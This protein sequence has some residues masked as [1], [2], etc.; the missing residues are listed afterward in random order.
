MNSARGWTEMAESYGGAEA[1]W[2]NKLELRMQ[3]APRVLWAVAFVDVTGI[4]NTPQ[5]IF[6]LSSRSFLSS[7]GVGLRLTTPWVPLRV[8]VV[9]GF[10]TG[11]SAAPANEQLFVLTLGGEVF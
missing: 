6:P 3:A 7:F 9:R 10:Q 8:Y 5:D 4:W 1:M 2:T 11:M